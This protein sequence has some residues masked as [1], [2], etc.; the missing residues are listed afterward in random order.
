MLYFTENGKKH[1]RRKKTP[2]SVA[3]TDAA[4]QMVDRMDVISAGPSMCG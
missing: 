1:D 3:A 2:P 4:V